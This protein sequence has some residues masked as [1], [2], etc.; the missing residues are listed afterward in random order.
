MKRKISIF[1]LSILLT[2]CATKKK[3]I[4]YSALAGS[5]L[6]MMA[7]KELSPNKESDGFNQAL[8]AVTGAVVMGLAGN[9]MYED[10]HPERKMDVSPIDDFHRKAPSEEE[11]IQLGD[12]GI[13]QYIPEIKTSTEKLYY[14]QKGE[15][16][17]NAMRQYVIKHKTQEKSLIL[18]NGKKYVFPQMTILEYG[19]E[20]E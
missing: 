20:N 7:G 10:R 15:H 19:V 17:K 13:P 16:L 4:L 9:M 3:T 12:L 5:A 18:K 1:I 2:S 11:G 14:T 6:G 8:G